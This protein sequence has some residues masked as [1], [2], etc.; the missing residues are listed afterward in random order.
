[1]HWFGLYND[2][3][4][5]LV[6]SRALNW[7]QLPEFHQDSS[8]KVNYVS[9]AM[10]N[11]FALIGQ[12]RSGYLKQ[13]LLDGTMLAPPAIDSPTVAVQISSDSTPGPTQ[14]FPAI[15]SSAWLAPD[16]DAGLV[17]TNISTIPVSVS[18]PIDFAQLKLSE[19]LS[20]SISLQTAHGISSVASGVT[21]STAVSVTVQ[22]YD[23]VALVVRAPDSPG[24]C[25]LTRE[26]SVGVADIQR[27]VNEALGSMMPTDDLNEDRAVNVVDVQILMN[28]ALQ[29]GCAAS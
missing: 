6:F 13:F 4:D 5:S 23:V 10:V 8:L 21:A 18:V 14:S 3:Y 15:Q 2:G 1:M 29:Q 12:A 26:G 9:Q 11:Y 22:P 17:L 16:G 24:R 27:I 19:A 7:G 20:Y 28:A 25:D